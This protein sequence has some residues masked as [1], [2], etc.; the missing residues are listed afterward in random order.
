MSKTVKTICDMKSLK[1]ECYHHKYS[2]KALQNAKGAT[3]E[4][5]DSLITMNSYMWLLMKP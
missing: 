2:T 5:L 3:R 1:T 4:A